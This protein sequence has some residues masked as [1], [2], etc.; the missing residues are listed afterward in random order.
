MFNIF[1]IPSCI[2]MYVLIR[3]IPTPSIRSTTIIVKIGDISNY[4]YYLYHFLPTLFYKE[5][6]FYNKYIMEYNI[7]T[8]FKINQIFK[9]K[10][11]YYK[12]GLGFASTS[13]DTVSGERLLSPKDDFAFFYN[14]TYNT[15]INGQGKIG[16]IKFYTDHYINED[17]LAFYHDKEEFI[18]DFDHQMVKE[19]GVDFYLG[20]LIKKIDIEKEQREE[21]EKMKKE[22]SEKYVADPNKIIMNPGQATYA[23]MVAYLEKKKSERLKT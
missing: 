8:N 18:F 11:K 10:S 2:G 9:Q 7:V 5:K 23:D 17:K 21:E 15:L 3:Y 13:V 22:N 1:F 12:V 19:K 16:N 6:I 20:H 14:R 4:I